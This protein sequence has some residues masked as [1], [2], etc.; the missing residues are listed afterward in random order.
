M[1]K[2][3]Q[4]HINGRYNGSKGA[5]ERRRGLTYEY[6]MRLRQNQKERFERTN[7]DEQTQ[8]IS[9]LALV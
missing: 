3:H 5:R 7:P 6:S 2:R 1:G 4:A 9:E 8:K